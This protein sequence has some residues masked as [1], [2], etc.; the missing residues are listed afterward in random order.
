MHT[1]NKH[2]ILTSRCQKGRLL[3]TRNCR[4]S[5]SRTE[6][7]TIW[8]WSITDANQY[9]R[10]ICCLY[11][12]RRIEEKSCRFFQHLTE[13]LVC[14]M[15][16]YFRKKK[17]FPLL[18]HCAAYCGKTLQMFRDDIWVPYLRVSSSWIPW[19]LKI[20]ITTTCCMI[21]KKGTE[22]I[23]FVAETWNHEH[24]RKY[25]SLCSWS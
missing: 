10:D 8:P 11:L 2:V 23:Y 7:F 24:F 4:K 16:K 14:Y 20:R 22:F 25:W 15:T 12:Q 13:C 9:F 17:I 19:P 3:S 5:V 21:P 18:R 6:V 1:H